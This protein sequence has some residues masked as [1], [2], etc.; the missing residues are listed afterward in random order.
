MNCVVFGA[1]AWGT[2]VA[3]AVAQRHDVVLWGRNADAMR[4][5]RAGWRRTRCC[6][7]RQ[8]YAI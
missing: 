6:L 7:P 1:G 5:M 8:R 3:M 4:A 2:A